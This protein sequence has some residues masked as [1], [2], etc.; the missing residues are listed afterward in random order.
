MIYKL[1]KIFDKSGVASLTSRADKFYDNILKE[2]F[3]FSE[4]DIDFIVNKFLIE[5]N[6]KSFLN[7]S[8]VN[9]EET[10]KSIANFMEYFLLKKYYSLMTGKKGK[11]IK[12]ITIEQIRKEF[13]EASKLVLKY[14]EEKLEEKIE[15]ND[16]SFKLKH[17]YNYFPNKKNILELGTD[18][19]SE[20]KDLSPLLVDFIIQSGYPIMVYDDGTGRGK[21][22]AYTV[23]LTLISTNKDLFE[24]IRYCF[25]ITDRR[26]NVLQEF[27]SFCEIN[28][29]FPEIIDLALPV[30][31]N[32]D[33]IISGN[34]WDNFLNL[35]EIYKNKE[36]YILLN[37]A[38]KYKEY[39][40]NDNEYKKFLE[41][42]FDKAEQGF[43]KYVKEFLKVI[44]EDNDK[45]TNLD[46]IKF[47]L[48]NEEYSSI[49]GV[50]SNILLSQKKIL[51][52]TLSKALNYIDTIIETRP[53]V[54]NTDSRFTK[55]S[56]Y[57][58]DESDSLSVE[59]L[60]N[61]V[62]NASKNDFDIIEA[63]T[64]LYGYFKVK[65]LPNI[66][67]S[68]I[69][70]E[71]K[72]K[73]IEKFE[74]YCDKYYFNYN[75]I[76]EK[77]EGQHW[78]FAKNEKILISKKND[79]DEKYLYFDA[80]KEYAVISGEKSLKK[81]GVEVE[82]YP[83][84]ETFVFDIVGLL[85]DYLLLI[86]LM[87]DEHFKLNRKTGATILTSIQCVL[88]MVGFNETHI[89]QEQL[90]KSISA[91]SEKNDKD[92]K[93]EDFY[94]FPGALIKTELVDIADQNVRLNTYILT[95][96]PE[97][98]L[99]DLVNNGAKVILSSATARNKSVV[100]NFNL[101][102]EKLQNLIY[103][104]SEK[105]KKLDYAYGDEQEKFKDKVETRIETTK[106][107]EKELEDYI[108]S[109]LK[110][111]EIEGKEYLKELINNL[112]N[113]YEGKQIGY[114]YHEF[115]KFISDILKKLEL[116]IKGSLFLLQFN[117]V[118]KKLDC[119][120]PIFN[121][122][123]KV[124]PSFEY[125]SAKSDG[126]IDVS[127]K[128]T[129]AINNGK[130]AFIFTS[131]ATIEKGFN[132]KIKGKYKKDDFVVLN[133]RGNNILKKNY[134][135]EDDSYNIGCDI[136]GLY[137]GAITYVLPSVDKNNLK[138]SMLKVMY[139][140]QS[141]Y[142]AGEMIPVSE[143]IEDCLSQNPYPFSN[144]QELKA[145]I[146]KI[147]GIIIQVVGRKN[148]SEF[149]RYL[150]HITLNSNIIQKFY[151]KD[152]EE[153]IDLDVLKKQCF[154]VRRVL[155]YLFDSRKAF[156]IKSFN[157]EGDFERSNNKIMELLEENNMGNPFRYQQV[158]KDIKAIS[159]SKEKFNE[160]TGDSKDFFIL[161]PEILTGGYSY[162]VQ[163]RIDDNEVVKEIFDINFASRKV[164][165]ESLDLSE[166]LIKHLE[167]RGFDFNTDNDYILT[168]KGFEIFKGNIGEEIA[169]LFVKK[170]F[171]KNFESLP[172]EVYEVMDSY[173]DFDSFVL[174]IDAKYFTF[175]NVGIDNEK[176][177]LRNYKK[178][179]KKLQKYY[180]KPV[181][182]IEIN[183]KPCSSD[184]HVVKEHVGLGNNIYF[185][186][187]PNIW[188]EEEF[189]IE[190]GNE[191]L[192]KINDLGEIY[193]V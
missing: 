140:A 57:F 67:N 148:R 165:K 138:A 60:N 52:L 1:S 139:Y 66:Y 152:I 115:L 10:F 192:R 90:I 11:E 6:D 119:C 81:Q 120:L 170:I 161:R 36:Y 69:I 9:E 129:N 37:S 20:L 74:E 103:I 151:D 86:K 31:T 94:D 19:I 17:D 190:L 77:D 150:N 65:K 45:K 28:K 191:I 95:S 143:I 87:S 174:F 34:H 49:I 179:M 27:N 135:K 127:Q 113:I 44:F 58:L 163:A 104:P 59:I 43:R 134:N 147:L 18:N 186:T 142:E 33:S 16:V 130:N 137:I 117:L 176:E 51:F 12:D 101:D 21:S 96:S 78:L 189:D 133:D 25:Y 188:K 109:S 26:N 98:F 100:R 126:L 23:L 105:A 22:H 173:Y 85:N 121:L 14:N 54:I 162:D 30:L 71:Q 112:I 48:N 169:N 38:R 63:L 180:N 187:I 159:I 97:K 72:I 92:E 41:D 8:S 68:S 3:D 39:T 164:S 46:K 32:K 123:K 13:P 15:V 7:S 80:E 155:E 5:N 55:D 171:D 102:W 184:M 185:F 124:Y 110:L 88:A 83:K 156:G 47:L 56:L 70:N 99:Y 89:N 42:N 116:N 35:S 177:N 166:N 158:Q 193:N 53:I 106:T 75:I 154:E 64:I 118:E 4:I 122:I 2:N 91:I 93:S 178:K 111:S 73:C 107:N 149:K 24:K 50:Y 167:L 62:E 40:G 132:L 114:Y 157:R 82:K 175:K 144:S 145:S 108:I 182:G 183:A 79:K 131:F 128:F 153:Y 76:L 29:D 172:D 125:F 141:I 61:I 168:P 84:L 136:D 146:C 181:I 160:L